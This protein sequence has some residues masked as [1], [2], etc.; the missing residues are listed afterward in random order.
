MHHCGGVG[1]PAAVHRLAGA[2]VVEHDNGQN[3]REVGRIVRRPGFEEEV[4]RS[5]GAAA[6]GSLINGRTDEFAGSD[7]DRRG[8]E[9]GSRGGL[10]GGG[11]AARRISDDITDFL[12]RAGPGEREVEGAA[13]GSRR[14][15]KLHR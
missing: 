5:V 9:C 14:T 2:V 15:R 12:S 7:R 6:L 10:R 8:V 4:L 3:G 11:S 1:V 13:E